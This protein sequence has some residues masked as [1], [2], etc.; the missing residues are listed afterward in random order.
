[1]FEMFIF[2]PGHVYDFDVQLGCHGHRTVFG[3]VIWIS[4]AHMP[5]FFQELLDL[6]VDDI[7]TDYTDFNVDDLDSDDYALMIPQPKAIAKGCA[8]AIAVIITIG[9]IIYA[10]I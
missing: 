5:E 6:N 10:A 4:S 7:P 9:L 1:M 2:K 3:R 8:I